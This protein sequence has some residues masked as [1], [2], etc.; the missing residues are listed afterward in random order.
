MGTSG[1]V[2][3]G[4]GTHYFC[5]L[6]VRYD[7]KPG[8]YIW[9]LEKT[10]LDS[11]ITK[12]SYQIIVLP[13]ALHGLHCTETSGV[14]DGHGVHYFCLLLVRYDKKPGEYMWPLENTLLERLMTKWGYQTSVLPVRCTP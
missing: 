4:E 13:A 7:K 6:V 1:D 5:L 11:L 3:G 8:E 2:I 10:P 14:V 12:W 9:A